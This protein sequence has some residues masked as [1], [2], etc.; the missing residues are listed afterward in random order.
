MKDEKE[1]KGRYDISDWVLVPN[2]MTDAEISQMYI[3]LKKHMYIK[4]GR[5]D[6]EIIHRTILQ[7]L[8]YGDKYDPTKASKLVWFQMILKNIYIQEIDPKYNKR[9]KHHYSLDY[10]SPEDEGINENSSIVSMVSF[11]T[12]DN[13]E[14]K[15]IEEQSEATRIMHKI[16]LEGDYPIIKARSEGLGVRQLSIK[17]G[18]STGSVYIKIK[19]ER[20]RLKSAIESIDKNLIAILGQRIHINSRMPSNKHNDERC[21]KKSTAG[22]ERIEPLRDVRGNLIKTCKICNK[23]FSHGLEA[24]PGTKTCSPECSKKN[25][26]ESVKR[27][28]LRAKNKRL[29]N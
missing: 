10:T 11:M 14:D 12:D 20:Q 17:L 23:V 29:E 16:L 1:K 24:G 19:D 22:I 28:L 18:I 6:E 15:L 13:E 2:F 8:R 3:T 26:E 9:I 4:W 27:T 5:Y 21:K 7:G 25:K